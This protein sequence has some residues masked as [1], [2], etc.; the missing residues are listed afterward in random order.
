MDNFV[1]K[2]QETLI[3]IDKCGTISSYWESFLMFKIVKIISVKEGESMSFQ[4]IQ[5]VTQIE[6]ETRAQKAEAQAQARQI[7]ADAH[8][9]G[10]GAV[11]AARSQAE[12]RVRE[13]MAQAEELAARQSDE[14]MQANDAACRAMRQQAE[15]R[16][17]EAAELIVRRVVN[18]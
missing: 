2:L 17:D 16:L 4:D 12:A 6:Q 11:E 13:L 15:T 10:R 5:K 18:R 8:K 1:K 14:T 3:N 9:A 7:V